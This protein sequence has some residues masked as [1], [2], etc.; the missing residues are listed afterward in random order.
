MTPVTETFRAVPTWYLDGR[1][2]PAADL[3]FWKEQL[4]ALVLIGALV[5][6]DAFWSQVAEVRDA[7]DTSAVSWRLARRGG[8]GRRRRALQRLLVTAAE[9]GDPDT[10]TIRAWTSRDD[11]A[12]GR[13]EHYNLAQDF[14]ALVLEAAPLAAARQIGRCFECDAASIGGDYC[15]R[16]DHSVEVDCK[17]RHG[18]VVDRLYRFA[19][20][21]ILE[22]PFPVD[23][24]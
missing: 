3:P 12:Q 9:G 1:G 10:T 24:D 23:S 17:Y 15:R 13:R 7:A 14:L 21:A 6:E 4:A 22:G 8:K 2:L 18:Y 16:H 5:R 19:L 11:P 20:P